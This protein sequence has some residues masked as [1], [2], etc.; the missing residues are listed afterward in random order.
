MKNKLSKIMMPVISS[1]LISGAAFAQTGKTKNVTLTKDVNKN[2]KN[3]TTHIRT[4]SEENGKKVVFDTI[5]V[6]PTEAELKKYGIEM[7]ALP[8]IPEVPEVPGAPTPPAKV[9]RMKKIVI[10]DDGMNKDS[11]IV[12]N[13]DD[14]DNIPEVPDTDGSVIVPCPPGSHAKMMKKIIITDDGNGEDTV[15]IN[16]MINGIEKELKDLGMEFKEGDGKKVIVIKDEN[17]TSDEK[18]DKKVL[19]IIVKKVEIKD[20]SDEEI[21]SQRKNLT[22]ENN[23]KVDQLNFYPNPNNG[24]FT[25]SFNLKEKGNTSITVFSID[26]KKVYNEN[27]KDFSGEYTKAID[28]T[29]S[30]KGVYFLNVMQ[31]KNN[32]VKKIVIE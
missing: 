32:L 20:A 4:V 22:G 24:K 25:L 21:K 13:L 3:G 9:M 1:L 23:L 14:L 12:V 19:K 16:E 15:T 6:N 18:G 29:G 28:L 8:E 11:T 7:Q 31:G 2:D 5:L 10:T 27:L 26:G 17:I 30:P